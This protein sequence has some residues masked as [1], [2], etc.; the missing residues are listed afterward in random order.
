MAQNIFDATLD[1]NNEV[2][3]NNFDWQH[4]NNFTTQIGTLTPIFCDLLP[5]HSVF[6]VNPRF[7]LQFMPMVNAAILLRFN[8]QNFNIL[9]VVRLNLHWVII[10][11]S[12]S[13]C[14]FD[15]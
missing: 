1:P 8:I 10:D 3:I 13:P 14:S 2:K 7:A 5:A 9:I 11:C 4:A 15:L 12:F 6:R